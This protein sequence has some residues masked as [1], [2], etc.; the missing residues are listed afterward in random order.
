M[1]N[2][3]TSALLVRLQFMRPSNNDST[4]LCKRQEFPSVFPDALIYLQETNVMTAMVQHSR[5]SLSSAQQIPAFMTARM[6]DEF[7][8]KEIVNALILQ[9]RFL[10]LANHSLQIAGM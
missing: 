6:K 8:L 7:T 1:P 2:T 3:E 4:L 5:I 9:L 10:Q